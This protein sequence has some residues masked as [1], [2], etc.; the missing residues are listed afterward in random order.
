MFKPNHNYDIFYPI[1]IT[2]LSFVFYKN[3]LNFHMLK[4]K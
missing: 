4:N 3:V 2:D 1:F